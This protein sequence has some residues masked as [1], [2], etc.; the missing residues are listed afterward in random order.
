MSEPVER[1]IAGK[2]ER[3]LGPLLSTWESLLAKPIPAHGLASLIYVITA[4]WW[5]CWLFHP[6]FL[7]FGFFETVCLDVM[8]ISP[9]ANT[10]LLIALLA[11]GRRSRWA[12]RGWVFAAGICTLSV[13]VM[14]FASGAI[15]GRAGLYAD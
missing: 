8:F 5:P 10:V 14:Y 4:V 3:A 11:G 2:L 15:A 7:H 6:H 9:F 13:W 1:R 12:Q